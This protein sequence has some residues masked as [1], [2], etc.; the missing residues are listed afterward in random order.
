MMRREALTGT[1]DEQCAFLYELAVEKMAQG[2][3]TGAYHA[4][5][6]VV[7]HKPDFEEA[8]ILFAEAKK[9]KSE[10]RLLLS[11]SFLGVI[12]AVGV[13]SLLGIANDIV[14]LGVAVV[15]GLLGYVLGVWFSSFR[16]RLSEN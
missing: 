15:G 11:I 6:D 8:Q 9:K 1:L 13:G 5:K 16:E 10:Q 7:K 14:F 2:N 3:Y 4:L 12:A